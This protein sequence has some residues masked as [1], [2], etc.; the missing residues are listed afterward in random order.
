MIDK[1]T[2][3]LKS[4]INEIINECNKLNKPYKVKGEDLVNITL[5]LSRESVQNYYGIVFLQDNIRTH[6][7]LLLV[8][9]ILN[10]SIEY[11]VQSIINSGDS[12]MEFKNSKYLQ[13]TQRM[14]E[15]INEYPD[16]ARV[17]LDEKY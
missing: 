14:R 10:E 5:S 11:N 2:S 16:E 3:T 6:S 17:Y 1:L 9:S 8:H 7:F 15:L 4:K 13:E 12:F